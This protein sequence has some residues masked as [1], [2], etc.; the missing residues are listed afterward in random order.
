MVHFLPVVATIGISYSNLTNRFVGH[1]F[2]NQ[3]I[4]GYAGVREIVANSVQGEGAIMWAIQFAAKLYELLVVASLSAIILHH[5]RHEILFGEVYRWGYLA[6][7]CRFNNCRTFGLENTERHG[8][9][10][11]AR[12][13]R[14]G[15]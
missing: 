1:G 13:D 5:T 2:V 11:A 7:H 10:S 6:V 3:H 14:G 12:G 9:Q 15:Y 8:R 4:F